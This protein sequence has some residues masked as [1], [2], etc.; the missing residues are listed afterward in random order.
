MAKWR[1]RRN[2]KIIGGMK[3]IW[4]KKC[5]ERKIW[6]E[7][8]SEWNQAR[9]SRT[10]KTDNGAD[11]LCI[12]GTRCWTHRVHAASGASSGAGAINGHRKWRQSAN[13]RA[14]GK[15]SKTIVK[16]WRHQNNQALFGGATAGHRLGM[17]INGEIKRR[18]GRA[19]TCHLPY[20]PSAPLHGAALC[21]LRLGAHLCVVTS[22]DFTC[23]SRCVAHGVLFASCP[24]D[25]PLYAQERDACDTSFTCIWK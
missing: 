12:C 25:A 10:L 21:C 16:A 19:I 3:R 6:A 15:I 24:L 22:C 9:A 13:R 5:N 2:R 18:G 20:L 11:A 1:E 8:M 17:R 7:K 23:V 4:G 14:A